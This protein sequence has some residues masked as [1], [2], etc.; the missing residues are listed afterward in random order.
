MMKESEII[1]KFKTAIRDL[2]DSIDFVKIAKVS[3]KPRNLISDQHF[4][5]DLLLEIRPGSS[6]PYILIFEVKSIGQPKYARMA[7]NQLQAVVN[8]QKNYYGVFGAPFISDESKRICREN[9]IGY[10]DLAGNCQIQF[11]KVYINVEGKKNPYPTT[12]PLKSIFAKKSTRGLRVLLCNPG[13]EW[14]VKNFA[15]E[16][17]ISLGQAFNLKQ[18][19]L[20]YELIEEIENQKGTKFAL[21]ILTPYSTNG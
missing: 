6:E 19:L 2:F 3:S 8:N 11:D 9:N 4:Q 10:L 5:P 13:K 15:Y 7:V 1:D 18:R 14:F 12:R 17:D 16:A 20:D 21:K